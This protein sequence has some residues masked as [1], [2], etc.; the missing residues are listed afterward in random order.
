MK[1]IQTFSSHIITGGKHELKNTAVLLYSE[2]LKKRHR[3]NP[4]N[5]E[6]L[7]RHSVLLSI[8]T[9]L[10]RIDTPFP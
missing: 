8:D 5:R 4:S 3:S 7:F 6:Y 2:M 1:I 9:V 10:L